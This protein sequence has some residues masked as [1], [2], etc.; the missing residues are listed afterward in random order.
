MDATR[1]R[2][3][4]Q[5]TRTAISLGLLLTGSRLG[6]AQ[7]R[8]RGQAET[9]VTRHNIPIEAQHDPIFFFRESTFTP[10]VGGYFTGVNARGE[11]VELQLI[12]VKP[13]RVENRITDRS[14]LS[15][16]FALTFRASSELPRFTSIHK[17]NHPALGDFE[18]FLTPRRGEN[19]ELFYEA[20]FNHLRL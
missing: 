19:R 20:V 1:R 2:F 13:F 18:L 10:Y 11:V 7:K 17:I 6:L 14:L 4:Q 8:G 3:I 12:K 5:G 15:D 9:T 16:S